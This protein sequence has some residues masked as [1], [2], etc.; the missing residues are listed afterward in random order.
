MGLTA[1]ASVSK[2]ST[3]AVI[4]MA[5]ALT[6]PVSQ[7][8]ISGQSPRP[9]DSITNSPS[10]HTTTTT[11]TGELVSNVVATENSQPNIQ[12]NG[13]YPKIAQ[14]VNGKTSNKLAVTDD[15]HT[16]TNGIE[17]MDQKCSNNIKKDHE[18]SEN[19]AAAAATPDLIADQQNDVVTSTT[20][21]DDDQTLVKVSD[22]QSST[23]SSMSIQNFT[24]KET[25]EVE[26]MLGDLAASG[27]IDLMSVFKSLESAPVS[28][29][30]FDLAGGLSL[31]ND[32][33]VMNVYEETVPANTSPVKDP[34]ISELRAD[35]EKR[36]Q[37]MQRKCDFLLRRLRKLQ[38]RYM[39]QH[40]S[41]EIVGLIEHCHR[42]NR[43]KEREIALGVK[44]TP[45]L[46]DI[47][48]YQ[49]PPGTSTSGSASD[50]KLMPVSGSAI[51]NIIKKLEQTATNQKATYSKRQLGV[52]YFQSSQEATRN[53]VPPN[54]PGA[55]RAP[56]S[57]NNFS[58][59][60]R[61]EDKVIDQVDQVAGLLH[62]ELRMVERAI[63]SDATASSSGGESADEMIVYSN[64][65]Q[66]NVQISK[67]AAWRW[68]RDRSSIASRWTWLLAQ[69]SDL[70]YRIRQHNELYQQIKRTKGAVQLEGEPDSEPEVESVNGYRG[71]LPGG[72]K[73]VET[74]AD[75]ERGNGTSA[76][77]RA[78]IRGTFRKRKLLQTSNLHTISKKAAKSSTIKCG[79]YWPMHPCALCTGRAD[80]TGPRDLPDTMPESER[81]ALVDP[82]FHPVLS[83]PD[84]A[85][86]GVHFEAIMRVPEWQNRV[87]RY[88]QKQAS[89]AAERAANPAKFGAEG[90]Q[91]QKRKYRKKQ[92]PGQNNNN[93][94]TKFSQMF[95]NAKM[96]KQRKSSQSGD[97]GF[98]N[99]KSLH[100]NK[101][102]LGYNDGESG[103]SGNNSGRSKNAS[104]TLGT[105]RKGERTSDIRRSRTSYDIDNIIIPYSVA[106][107]TRVE[108]LPYKEIPT[109]KWNIIDDEVD[110]LLP[111]TSQELLNNKDM[112]EE[113]ISDEAL[114][115][116]H[117]RALLEERKKFAAVMKYPPG[118][119]P[120][121]NRRT[122]SH[123]DSS[124]TNT[125]INPTSPG[126][127]ATESGPPTPATP[128]EQDPD[129]SQTTIN[130][131]H[132]TVNALT[133]KRERRRTSSMKLKDGSAVDTRSNT[134]ELKETIPPY[135]QRIFPLPDHVFE[136]MLAEMPRGYKCIFDS[137]VLPDTDPDLVEEEVATASYHNKDKSSTKQRRTTN[138][139]SISYQDEEH[140]EEMDD[141]DSDRNSIVERLL[142]LEKAYDEEKMNNQDFSAAETESVDTD[143][144]P[145]EDVDDPNDPEWFEPL[146]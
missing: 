125:P 84:D 67:R 134:P 144:I 91:R 33:D 139:N 86:Q 6:E 55:I 80:P 42:F 23:I 106:A 47:L 81:I 93:N 24:S 20:R 103:G 78:F 51:R 94:R 99:K 102:G 39:T 11:I 58:C 2:V 59:V 69:I 49:P 75:A 95:K 142:L 129:N 83:F 15:L 88:T 12:N 96:Q 132:H 115:Q 38:A 9:G 14:P 143:D 113:D 21:D 119:R 89:K 19:P 101:A 116:M 50:A 97:G 36:R 62:A 13:K 121:A 8:D 136:E 74:E 107:Q 46:P 54:A 52:K 127:A 34:Q 57:A 27:D 133:G 146:R 65:T 76:R 92:K 128:L 117:E 111:F 37:Q 30:G 109:P 56:T 32:V 40:A 73:P 26:Q 3:D 141:D 105:E 53:S 145:E 60:H 112:L 131:L 114:M 28:D 79:C 126:P 124:G 137:L 64:T 66:Q 85:T 41:E 18:T 98:Y 44:P 4:A 104:P 90:E 100:L 43:R 123:A 120:R 118:N 10:S 77:T 22:S 138:N 82:G 35:I 108:V 7:S 1:A 16:T 110:D 45:L 63:D 87:S 29:A 61:F 70:E 140:L 5:P 25:A 48:P 71:V 17:H 135:D 122:D 31:F 68:A 130:A 72:S